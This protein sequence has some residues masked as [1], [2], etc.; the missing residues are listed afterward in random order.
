MG[1]PIALST[2]TLGGLPAEV[3]VPAY[4]RAGVTPGMVHFGVGGFIR[5]CAM[6]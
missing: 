3:A 5:G 4:D 6:R 2:A 1:A